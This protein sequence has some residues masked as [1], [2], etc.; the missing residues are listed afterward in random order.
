VS[1]EAYVRELQDVLRRLDGVAAPTVKSC[2]DWDWPVGY[3][4]SQINS[5]QLIRNSSH[6]FT[7]GSCILFGVE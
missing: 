2:L 5:S 3:A 4:Q 1:Y 7:S 6:S